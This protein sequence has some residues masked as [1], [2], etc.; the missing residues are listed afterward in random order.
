MAAAALKGKRSTSLAGLGYAPKDFP[1]E[2]DGVPFATGSSTPVW[3]IITKNP[4]KFTVSYRSVS[5]EIIGNGMRRFLADRNGK[6]HAGVDLYGNPGDK[7]LAMEDGEIVN[8]YHFFHGTYALIVQHAS[9]LVVNYG[10]VENASWAPFGLKRGS[11]V[12]KGSPIARIGL[13]SGGSHMLH[14]EAYAPG[15]T[16]N[17][18][19]TDPPNKRTRNPTKY[20]LVAK[21][22]AQPQ[23]QPQT[24]AAM[25]GDDDMIERELMTPR[26]VMANG[27]LDEADGP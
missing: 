4:R 5:G 3:P 14:F 20:L 17:Y 15:T 25:V 13:M 24:V 9:G 16:K 11:Y 8:F 27:P 22:L 26:L 6:L 7:V 2:V 21:G 19:I 10:E 18:K 23:G 1:K 12:K